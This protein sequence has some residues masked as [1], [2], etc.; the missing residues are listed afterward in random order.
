MTPRRPKSEQG[1]PYYSPIKGTISTAQGSIN[2][3]P[4]CI[5]TQL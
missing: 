4:A 1:I 2:A 5:A 3:V